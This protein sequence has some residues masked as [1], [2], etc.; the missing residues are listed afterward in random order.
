MLS[1]IEI[2][3]VLGGEVMHGSMGSY[4]KA[5]GKGHSAEDRS[6]S[7]MLT[8]DGDDIVSHSFADDDPIEAKD[9]I[10]E[11][12]RLPK[13]Q[14]KKKANGGGG[15]AWTLIGEY[16]YR[17]A[18]GQ[19]YLQVKK[20]L[21]GAGKK[22]YP[23]SHWDGS[24]WLKGKP[25]GPKIPYRLPQ[26]IEAQVSIPVYFCEGE[27]DADALAKLGFVAT[28]ASEGAKAAWDPDMTQHFAG[29]TVIILPDADAPGR[30]HAQKVAK[31]LYGTA[32]SIHVLDLFPE[33]TD[34]YD[35]SEFLKKDPS[36]W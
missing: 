33:R 12:L 13:W 1:L 17:T 5:P 29:R 15:G 27:K 26:L 21:D 25:A 18:E 20:Y 31:A 10:R 28:T 11:K 6:L 30:R 7:I 4:V 14:P 22:Q 19:P 34:G 9:W 35:V 36:G 3:K 8:D 23:Q 16:V 24:Q 2:A 32:H